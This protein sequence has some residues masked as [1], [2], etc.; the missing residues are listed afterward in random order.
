MTLKRRLRDRFRHLA[1]Y[2]KPPVEGNPVAWRDFYY[3][4]GGQRRVYLVWGV[5]LAAT[6][7]VSVFFHG[8]EL[9]GS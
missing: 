5:T 9:F 7:G 2:H 4:L 6:L 3:R 8:S 1:W